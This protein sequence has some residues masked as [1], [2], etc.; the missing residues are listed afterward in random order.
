MKLSRLYS[1]LFISGVVIS[2]FL[3]G[4][5]IA[6]KPSY[7]EFNFD[8]PLYMQSSQMVD[9][10]G[11]L[12]CR[13]G[14]RSFVPSWSYASENERA[15]SSLR[16]SLA[17]SGIRLIVVPIPEREV[18]LQK[19]FKAR[20]T[21]DGSNLQRFIRHLKRDGIE[22]ADLAPW[23]KKCK[24][25]S[26]YQKRDSH[27]DRK[28]ISIAARVIASKIKPTLPAISYKLQD[29]TIYHEGDIAVKAG[30]TAEYQRN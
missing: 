5:L 7:F 3:L 15:I 18:I 14:E 20:T 9:S 13:P 29:T 27:W 11:W 28:G 24:P 30:D 4:F 2:I 21:V 8:S 6:P 25:E 19:L 12:F 22:V 26:L 23:Y 16:D 10:G 17:D 1:I